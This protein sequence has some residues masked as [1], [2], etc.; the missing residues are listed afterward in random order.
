ML[1][2]AFVPVTTCQP[3]Q[4]TLLHHPELRTPGTASHGTPHTHCLLVVLSRSTPLP[5]LLASRFRLIASVREPHVHCDRDP[6]RRAIPGCRASQPAPPRPRGCPPSLPRSPRRLRLPSHRYG[7]RGACPRP[8][9]PASQGTTSTQAR[10]LLVSTRA[11]NA[12]FFL[13][14]RTHCFS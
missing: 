11:Q 3:H 6:R 13:D 1:P 4:Y 5:L 7:F 9:R 10:T 2:L 14:R 8:R 12:L